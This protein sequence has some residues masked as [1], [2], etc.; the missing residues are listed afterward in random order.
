LPEVYASGSWRPKE[1]HEGAFVEAWCDF[2]RWMSGLDGAGTVRLTR[3]VRDPGRYVSFSA[4]AGLEQMRAWKESVEFRPRM[5]K[6][7]EHVAEFTP[8]ELE[9]VAAIE[10]GA[11]VGA[12]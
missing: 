10:H 11:T 5:A 6:V 8:S 9:V 3:D 2:A 12:R 4:W 1:G 7:Q